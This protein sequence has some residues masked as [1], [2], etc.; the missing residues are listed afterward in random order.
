MAKDI[1]QTEV[2]RFVSR[3]PVQ[4]VEC[5]VLERDRVYCYDP[6][7]PR[8]ALHQDLASFSF[9]DQIVQRA[10]EYIAEGD[11]VRDIKGL[12][13]AIGGL[14]EWLFTS[15]KPVAYNSLEQAV[16]EKF[17]MPA[18]QVIGLEDYQEDRLRLGD[19]IMAVATDSWRLHRNQ[20]RLL[21]ALRICRLLERMAVNDTALQGPEGIE[22]A[23]EAIVLL[24]TD[25]FP[26]PPVELRKPDTGAGGERP[27]GKERIERLRQRLRDLKSALAEFKKLDASDYVPWPEEETPDSGTSFGWLLRNEAVNK[28]SETTKQ[29]LI[30]GGL[31]LDQVSAPEAMQHLEAEIARRGAEL[32]GSSE[33]LKVIRYGDS[34]Y[35]FREKAA[36]TLPSSTPR[37]I[38]VTVPEGAGSA[39][40][41]GMADLMLVRQ[42]LLRYELGEIAHIENVLRGESKERFH[43]RSR[44][45]EE[46]I[47]TETE[48]VEE[49]ERDLESTERFELKRECTETVKEES[50]LEAG[51]SLSGSYGP[52]ISFEANTNYASSE[53]KEKSKSNSA[54]YS[55]DVVEHAVSRLEERVREERVRRI[56]EEFE[57]TNKHG[58]DNKGQPDHVI[59][60][61]RWVDKI[62]EQQVANYGR[63]LLYEF[64]VPEPAAFY[65]YALTNKPPEGVAV[66]KPEPPEVDENGNPVLPGD[67]SQRRPLKPQDL[68]PDNYQHWVSKY[69]VSDVEPYPP[70]FKFSAKQL[71]ADS[72]AEDGAATCQSAEVEG[73]ENY[74][75]TILAI[76]GVKYSKGSHSSL[77]VVAGKTA[78]DFAG[79]DNMFSQTVNLGFCDPDWWKKEYGEVPI[80]VVPANVERF[81]V[82]FEFRCD[83]TEEGLSKWQLTTYTA[84]MQ[85]YQALKAAYDDHL[86]AAAIQ[87][88]ISISGRN[89]AQNREI[90]KTELKKSA[91]SVAGGHHLEVFDAMRQLDDAAPEIDF[92]EAEAEG[93]YIQFFEQAFEWPHMTYVFYPYFWGRKP[94]PGAGRWV[95]K[96]TQIRDTDPQFEEFLKAGAARIVLPVRR[97]Y[98]A[99]LMHF[100]E[101]GGEIWGGGDPPHVDEELYVSIVE[102]IR[103]EQGVVIEKNEGTVSVTEG[104]DAVVGTGTAFAKEDVD[105]EI[106]IL[107]EKYRIADVASPTNLTLTESYR[108][109]TKEHAGYSIGVRL[110]GQPWDVRLPTSLVKLQQDATLPGEELPAGPSNNS[111]SGCLWAWIKKIFGWD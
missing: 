71:N 109:P 95:D 34:S 103:E 48:R 44:T 64:V 99:A 92:K 1:A 12:K 66:E 3:R 60:V 96:L 104:S 35:T 6:E 53:A 86:A 80:G 28:L 32:Y 89:P 10:Q 82:S 87:E 101:T 45:I 9:R 16:A 19:S 83:L 106:T 33:P 42:R 37:P 29:L 98:E 62:Y 108:G 91:I 84:I 7:G 15:E 27:S 46:M 70:S 57:E 25:V 21:R 8:T 51:L 39:R 88:G 69:R 41:I 93:K 81:M 30:D 4:R 38:D 36:R 2:F 72:S 61:Y 59:G 14:E 24:P 47:T 17:G 54:N 85:A 26:L 58:I 43:R 23:C 20:D 75:P 76:A 65:L 49:T 107:K 68:A 18:A 90:E 100:V 73:E 40:P 110:V 105:R 5:E 56:V 50:K 102:E 13:T 97:G 31:D 111:N 74:I 79:D 52:T 63:R 77:Y 22:R 67:E 55:R 78:A 11:F 94:D